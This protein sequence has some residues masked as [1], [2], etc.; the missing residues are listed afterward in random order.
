MMMPANY[1]AI[2]EIE[3][4]YV[5]GGASLENILAPALTE[6]NWQQ[7]NKNIVTIIGNN[8]VEN[9]VANT[10]GVVFSGSYTPF[11]ATKNNLDA[12]VGEWQAV[13]DFKGG[14]LKVLNDGLNVVGNLA[15]VYNLAT[16]SVANKVNNNGFVKFEKQ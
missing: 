1:S 13:T 9:F 2:S 10:L 8:Y 5:N 3:M 4:T 7:F 16:G 12:Y 14:A 15:A 11:K 6:A